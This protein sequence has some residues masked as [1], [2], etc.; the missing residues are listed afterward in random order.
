[1]NLKDLK[2]L[3]TSLEGFSEELNL[4]VSGQAFII[5]GY[6]E[7]DLTSAPSP[8]ASKP[9]PNTA[10]RSREYNWT[11]SNNNTSASTTPPGYMAVGG[12]TGA[13]LDEMA[14]QEREAKKQT[15][16]NLQEQERWE[17]ERAREESV[18]ELKEF[19]QGLKTSQTEDTKK[20]WGNPEY[21]GNL[22]AVV[23]EVKRKVNERIMDLEKER[24]DE[25]IEEFTKG[26]KLTP[27][28][29]FVKL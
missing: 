29:Y 17:Q 8:N 23:S 2:K 28:L 16:K 22:G 25:R 9:T 3:Q 5:T 24:S 21:K 10:D 14:R 4:T 18:Q 19:L 20:N 26:K 7:R 27:G 11:T 15:I 6:V 1:M 12:K 13:E